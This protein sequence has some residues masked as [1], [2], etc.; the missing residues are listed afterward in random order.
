MSYRI[1]RVPLEILPER[2][3]AQWEQWFP[4]EFERCGFDYNEIPGVPLTSKVETGKVLDAS[5]TMYFKFSQ[6]QRI[7]ELFK[8]GAIRNNDVFF[9]DDIQY[10]GVWA[11]KYMAQLYGM[12]V[13]VF[14]YLHASSYT[15]EDFA[16]PMTPF[17][18]NVEKSWIFIYDKIFVGTNYHKKSFVARRF[19]HSYKRI[20]RSSIYVSGAP[21]NVWTAQTLAYK[22]RK[23]TNG[24][25]NR[26]I[27]PNRFD[28]E[29]RPNV[30]L[31]LVDFLYNK[32]KYTDMEFLITTSRQN[33]TSDPRLTNMLARAVKL[34]PTLKIMTGL[35]K[36]Q[37]YSE[38]SKSKLMLSTT[39]EE[40][41]GYCIV[42]ALT[43]NTPVLVPNDYSHP[44]LL[45]DLKMEKSMMLYDIN[46]DKY[47]NDFVLPSEVPDWDDPNVTNL[48]G[49]MLCA[50]NYFDGPGQA[51]TDKLYE[52]VIKYN[53]SIERMCAVMKSVIDHGKIDG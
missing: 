22:S 18:K 7:A 46:W 1:F 16:E 10:P 32:M 13:F 36:E 31:K 11:I 9:F 25:L 17:L 27:Y 50:A 33:V 6:L 40:N 14:G 37:Y 49:K 26:L 44:E 19:P 39:I 35:S 15:K 8:K 2:Y 43:L 21:W 48:A 52:A 53:K 28:I 51:K 23:D 29:K 47:I 20:A 45:S 38:L 24:K 42:E 41:F 12:R 5:G 3:T 34:V 30:F 4:S